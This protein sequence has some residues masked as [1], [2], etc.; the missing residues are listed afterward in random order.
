MFRFFFALM[1]IFYCTPSS[2]QIAECP[3]NQ[4]EIFD[5]CL[6]KKIYSNG[7]SYLGY[8]ADNK[9][10][11]TGLLKGN[12]WEYYGSFLNGE[13]HGYGVNI[14]NGKEKFYGQWDKNI[15]NGAGVLLSFD[16]K[17]VNSGTWEK[18]IFTKE[19][20]VDITLYIQIFKCEDFTNSLLKRI[21][22]CSSALNKLYPY[23]NTSGYLKLKGRELLYKDIYYNILSNRIYLY[24]QSG[25]NDLE[26]ADI[27]TRL[28]M[29]LTEENF[30]NLGVAYLKNG[31]CSDALANIKI[32]INSNPKDAYVM[33]YGFFHSA[34][35]KILC[36]EKDSAYIDFLRS[37]NDNKTMLYPLM[38]L[39]ISYNDETNIRDIQINSNTNM[40]QYD[41]LMFLQKLNSTG[42]ISDSSFTKKYY[43]GISEQQKNC[44]YNFYTGYMYFVKGDISEASTYINFADS[45]CP[46]T[47]FETNPLKFLKYVID[48]YKKNPPAQSEPKATSK[49][50]SSSGSGF[51]VSK[52]YFVTNNHVVDGCS[53]I[54]L[55]DDQNLTLITKDSVSDIAIL[56]LPNDSGQS[57][58]IRTSSIKLNE[59][60]IAVGYPLSS[61][62]KGVSVTSGS[63]SRLSGLGGNDINFQISAP[64]QPG[65]SGG[66]VIDLNGNIVGI[67]VATLDALKVSKAIEAIPQNVNFAI[68]T[69]VLTDMLNRNKINYDTNNS[70]YN[71]SQTDLA[72]KATQY[73]VQIKCN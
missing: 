62:F 28:N 38:W 61:L 59:S 4:N 64:I 20:K 48:N 3:Q 70:T 24:R 50:S 73:T 54:T 56:Y 22:E 41:L 37:Y 65:N 36:K 14:I 68:K 8:W 45:F 63:I 21:E 6:G 33:K 46:L 23:I 26:I 29:K 52:G 9:P 66:P 60:I 43:S 69:N 58:K 25:S 5:R 27:K 11:G 44:E 7:V 39:L 12:D 2:A 34:I 40:W 51:R 57:A 17:F 32:G 49:A 53:K 42:K 18:D 16:D 10:N 15:R 19:H 72:E 55:M 13:R 67:V 71:L 35:T 30:I 31:N 1:V 47:Y